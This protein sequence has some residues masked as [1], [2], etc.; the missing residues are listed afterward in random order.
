MPGRAFSPHGYLCDES[1]NRNAQKPEMQVRCRIAAPEGRSSLT[2]RSR[3]VCWRFS[4]NCPPSGH[5]NK[6]TSPQRCIVS[7]LSLFIIQSVDFVHETA[8]LMDSIRSRSHQ[9]VC[10]IPKVWK[11]L[12]NV[13]SSKHSEHMN[14]SLNTRGRSAMQA[15]V[16]VCNPTVC[17]CL[18]Y[19]LD[20][21]F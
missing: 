2:P 7:P 4:L 15:T 12:T 6:S 3:Y 18:Q 20:F 19:E 5:Q 13:G 11:K 1:G 9:K 21:V 17:S 10:T 16:N 14:R 8:M